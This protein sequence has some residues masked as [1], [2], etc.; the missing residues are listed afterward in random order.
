MTKEQIE[1]RIADL[2]KQLGHAQANG[3]ALV[4]AI[5]DCEYWLA[6]LAQAETQNTNATDITKT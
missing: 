6:Q 1:K 4:G 2:Q 5:Q 3:N